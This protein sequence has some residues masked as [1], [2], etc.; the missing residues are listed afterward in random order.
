MEVTP[1]IRKR[2]DHTIS[3]LND[4]NYDVKQVHTDDYLALPRE[5][6]AIK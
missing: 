2:I 1:D 4:M 5:R 3:I 6:F